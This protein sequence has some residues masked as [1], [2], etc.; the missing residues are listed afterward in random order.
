MPGL[1][2]LEQYVFSDTSPYVMFEEIHKKT[3]II[4]NQVG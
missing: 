4:Q 2:V 3:G 1:T